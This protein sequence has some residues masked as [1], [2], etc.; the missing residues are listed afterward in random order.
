MIR[1]NAGMDRYGIVANSPA[2]SNFSGKQGFNNILLDSET[3]NLGL[4]NWFDPMKQ[5]L[6]HYSN[7]FNINT[8]KIS[9]VNKGQITTYPYDVNIGMNQTRKEKTGTDWKGNKYSFQMVSYETANI[10]ETHAQYYQL[11]LD[12]DANGDGNNDLIVWYSLVDDGR[13]Y[14]AYSAMPNDVRNN[15]YIYSLNN[16]TYTG[17]GQKN[18]IGTYEA[19]LFVNTMIAAYNLGIK[20]PTIDIIADEK[21]VDS[22]VDKIYRTYDEDISLDVSNEEIF[23]YVHDKNMINGTKVLS[24]KYYYEVAEGTEDAIAH[25]N[26]NG[27]A[28]WLKKLGEREVGNDTVSAIELSG[29]FINS[30]LALGNELKIYV[31]VQT[32]L[33]FASGRVETTS[34][35]FDTISVKKRELFNLD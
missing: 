15:Y 30:K 27:D 5:S 3:Y 26:E 11:D 10:Q 35:V 34:E 25:I 28:V 23:F 18:T 21:D 24:M 1:K 4:E 31:G 2:D 22:S 33:D 12:R 32:Q 17:M 20:N 8:S 29:E 13:Q 9:Q 16:V 19:K 6:V 7:G 14:S